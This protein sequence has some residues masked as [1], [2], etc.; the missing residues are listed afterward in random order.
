MYELQWDKLSAVVWPSLEESTAHVAKK[1]CA[2][3]AKYGKFMW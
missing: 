1:I 2:Y 3:T